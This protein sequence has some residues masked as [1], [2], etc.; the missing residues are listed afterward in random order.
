MKKLLLAIC[1]LSSVTS[2]SQEV[3]GI[4]VDGLRTEVINKFK[5]K[6][7]KVTGTPSVKAVTMEGTANG[8]KY[9]VVIV[10]TPTTKKVWKIGL[11]LS[12]QDDW[13]DIKATYEKFYNMLVEKYG[14]PNSSYTGFSSPYYEGDGYE[15]SAVGL[16]K[17]NY[18]AFWDFV[19]IEISQFKQVYLSYE[20]A[21]NS[22]LNTVENK[23]IDN[24]NF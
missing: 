11:Y 14:E 18:S 9:E 12:K 8:N 19:Y 22:E 10:N 17:C 4:K 1:L 6:G 5:A 13:Y 16:N 23:N 24:K 3:M 7:F 21:V 15:M 20:N 2:R